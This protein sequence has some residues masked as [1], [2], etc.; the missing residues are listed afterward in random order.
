MQPHNFTLRMFKGRFTRLTAA[1]SQ[2]LQTLDAAVTLY[3]GWHSFRWRPAKM[4]ITPAMAANVTDRLSSF[5]DLLA[6]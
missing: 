5:D 4:R 2:E 1:L 3:M 6:A